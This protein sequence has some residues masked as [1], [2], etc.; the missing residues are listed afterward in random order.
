MEQIP[1]RWSDCMHGGSLRFLPS[2]S[3][4]RSSQEVDFFSGS[5]VE[6]AITTKAMKVHEGRPRILKFAP[7]P[8][9]RCRDA[10]SLLDGVRLPFFAQ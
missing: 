8:D 6:K 2:V 7:A 5:A 1:F 9:V 10:A 3:K 4:G